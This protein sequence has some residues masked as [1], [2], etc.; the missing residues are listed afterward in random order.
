[1]DKKTFVTFYNLSNAKLYGYLLKILQDPQ[2]AEDFCQESFLKFINQAPGDLDINKRE[3]YLYSIAR[4]LF[5][6][7]FKRK[8]LFLNYQFAELKKTVKHYQ[9]ESKVYRKTDMDTIL[10]Y[11]KPKE[12]ELIVLTYID[13]KSH[14]EIAEITG[15]KEK[16]IKVLLSRCRSKIKLISI[17]HGL[18]LEE[19]YDD[20]R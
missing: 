4:R 3:A 9:I 8:K 17:K 12:R 16:S 1:M 10:S 7:Y 15:M 19:G 20:E 11:L 13:D 2:L 5:Y 14:Q 18:K 6:D